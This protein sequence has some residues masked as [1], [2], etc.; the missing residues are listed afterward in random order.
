MKEWLKRLL[1]LVLGDYSVYRIYTRPTG[2]VPPVRSAKG[3][4]FVVREVDAPELL[5]SQD[6][7]IREQAG[8]AGDGALAFACFDGDRI[9]GV[10]FYWFGERYL[11]RNF[12]PLEPGQAKLVQVITLPEMRGRDVASTLVANSLYALRDKGFERSFAR[13]WHSNTPSL[14]TF[15]RTGW[16]YVATVVEINPLRSSRPLR[17][18]FGR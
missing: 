6:G 12:W 10:C 14:R 3:A 4:G 5:A 15:G 18:K 7:L 16:S 13:I 17:F 11:K 2:G 8:Y 1:H 9:V